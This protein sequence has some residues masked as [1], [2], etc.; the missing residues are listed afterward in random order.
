M[1]TKVKVV[2]AGFTLIE[3]LIVVTI[4]SIL[5]SIALPAYSDYVRRGQLQES[6]ARLS[7]LRVK[8][9]QYYQD[10]KNYGVGACADAASASSWNAF[11]ATEYFTY[12]CALTNSGQ[13]F[14][15][16]ATGSNG[17]VVGYNYTIDQDGT[18]ATALFAGAASTCS[19]VWQTRRGQC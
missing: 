4:L 15:V 18:K 16:T 5:A 3:V 7:D 13:G 8:M 12:G 14:T 6:F 19:T 11:A 9:E 1:S 2:S 17:L 10:N